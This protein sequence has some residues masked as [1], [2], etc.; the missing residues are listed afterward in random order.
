M[1]IHD[2]KRLNEALEFIA[3]ARDIIESIGE[4][5]HEKFDN[6]PEGL[7]ASE[8]GEKMEAAADE[9]DNALNTIDD[10]VSSIETALE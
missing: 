10:V 4:S 8:C 1:N 7:Q 6:L 3:K 9:L 2:R 5:E